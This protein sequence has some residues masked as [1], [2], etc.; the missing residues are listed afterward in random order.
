MVLGTAVAG[1]GAQAEKAGVGAASPLSETTPLRAFRG[2]L[3]LLEH[4]T[5]VVGVTQCPT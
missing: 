1:S 4:A 2:C 3:E 5:K